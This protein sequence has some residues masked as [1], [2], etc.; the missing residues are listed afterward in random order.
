MALSD[1]V[2]KGRINAALARD[3]RA[4]MLDVGV[5][6]DE[7]VV[8]LNGA[9][10]SLRE[11]RVAEEIVAEVEGVGPIRNNM[12]CG[13][14]RK[15]DSAEHIVDQFLEKLHDQWDLLPERNALAQA[16]YMRWAC[17]L[18]YKFHIPDMLDGAARADL[19]ADAV[20]RAL[21]KI[22]DLVG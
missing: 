19:E 9:A 2:L 10:D 15:P 13:T 17:W 5:D 22:A 11:C 7:G 14:G 6:V 20:E 8:V 1:M 12:V 18:T 21:V 4:R 3:I 16:D